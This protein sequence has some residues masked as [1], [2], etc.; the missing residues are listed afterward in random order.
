MIIIFSDY[1]YYLSIKDLIQYL[2][3]TFDGDEKKIYIKY[4]IIF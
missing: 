2:L 4:I 1:H 3:Y